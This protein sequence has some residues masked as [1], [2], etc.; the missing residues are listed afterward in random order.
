M[1]ANIM[2]SSS[3]TGA[4][5]GVLPRSSG[6]N[7][8]VQNKC[9]ILGIRDGRSNVRGTVTPGDRTSR[10]R[11]NLV[12]RAAVATPPAE[13]SPTICPRGSHWQVCS[14]LL[15]RSIEMS[16]D[17]RPASDKS[18]TLS[19]ADSQVRRYLRRNCRKN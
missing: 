14:S 6:L 17:G 4:T 3:S 12:I 10:G 9:T 1:L 2:L 18:P 11:C 5:R 19:P 8:Y 16:G 13:D 7:A 15:P